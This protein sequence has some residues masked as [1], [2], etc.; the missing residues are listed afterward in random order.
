M[1]HKI[2]FSVAPKVFL[3][4][5]CVK[6]LPGLN[7]QDTVQKGF[8]YTGQSQITVTFSNIC[9]QAFSVDAF[10]LFSNTDNGGNF[11]AKIEGFSIGVNQSIS[12]PVK[13]YGICLTDVPERN[14]IISLN[15]IS[16]N[17]KLLINTPFI[18]TPPTITNV[19]LLLPNRQDYTFHDN[20]FLP[21]YNDVDMHS[22]AA[23]ILEGNLAPFRLNG[24]IVTSPLEVSF[25]Q[26]QNGALKYIAQNT[27]DEIN[28]SVTLK[29]KDE[30]GGISN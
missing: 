4:G 24:N 26:L 18:N 17:Y 21:H 2:F 5:E 15:G 22:M 19:E 27:D 9:Q 30:L 3:V 29:A 23:V 14:Y 10:T 12:I 28:I 16:A 1:A 13:Y 11:S 25:Y 8:D 6:L 7:Y 20:D